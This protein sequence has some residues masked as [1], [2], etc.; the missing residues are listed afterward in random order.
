MH[1]LVQTLDLVSLTW[2][3][4]DYRTL[5]NCTSYFLVQHVVHQLPRYFRLP[6]CLCLIDLFR[7]DAP[8]QYHCLPTFGS[9]STPFCLCCCPPPACGSRSG[10]PPLLVLFP[11]VAQ[12]PSWWHR[13]AIGI[14]ESDQWCKQ[15]HAQKPLLLS[16]GHTHCLVPLTTGAR[17]YFRCLSEFHLH[18]PPNLTRHW[19]L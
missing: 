16:P 10:F 14:T 5:H 2:Q 4:T 15:P 6:H 11:L 9:G 13:T 19:K 7:Q 8:F 1:H 17:S 18:L 3:F 12:G